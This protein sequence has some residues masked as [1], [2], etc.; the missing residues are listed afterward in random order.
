MTVDP[1]RA[2]ALDVTTEAI[3]AFLG[4]NVGHLRFLGNLESEVGRLQV[5]LDGRPPR[6][7]GAG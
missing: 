2:A 4:T 6:P 3:T 7:G 5:I 1:D